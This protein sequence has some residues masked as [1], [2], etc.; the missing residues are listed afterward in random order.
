VLCSLVTWRKS[1][2]QKTI[3]KPTKA[4]IKVFKKKLIILIKLYQ[5]LKMKKRK[6]KNPLTESRDS[7][8]DL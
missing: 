1:R 2:T 7:I 3:K 4:K 6:R 8:S 5:A